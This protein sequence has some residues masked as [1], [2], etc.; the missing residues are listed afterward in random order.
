MRFEYEISDERLA[1][2]SQGAR[3]KLSETVQNYALDIVSEAEL[4]EGRSREE[5][6]ECEITESLFIRA[7]RSKEIPKKKKSSGALISKIVSEGSLLIAGLMFIP[8]VFVLNG[9]LNIMYT[10]IFVLITVVAVASTS[11]SY[12]LGGD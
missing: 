5:G 1:V 12:F 6:A 2:F 3:N 8:D 9:E 7:I 4:I 11:I 10:V